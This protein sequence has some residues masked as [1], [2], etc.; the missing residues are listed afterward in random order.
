MRQFVGLWLTQLWIFIYYLSS[1][2]HPVGYLADM[3]LLVIYGILYLGHTVLS[4]LESNAFERFREWSEDRNCLLVLR[5]RG[6]NFAGGL[7]SCQFQVT[8][9]SLGKNLEPVVWASNLAL[10]T[11]HL[12]MK[13]FACVN[14]KHGMFRHTE[15]SCK[16]GLARGFHFGRWLV[17]L[18][19]PRNVFHQLDIILVIFEEHFPFHFSHNI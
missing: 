17:C 15:N 13:S 14:F 16:G 18:L 2:A 1:L 5:S 6:S 10:K 3:F 11:V 9:L 4:D 8:V 12:F 19:S 7:L